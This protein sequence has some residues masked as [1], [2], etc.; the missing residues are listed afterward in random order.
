MFVSGIPSACEW[1]S[2]MGEGGGG[3]GGGQQL[4]GEE[5]GSKRGFHEG[6]IHQRE[7]HGIYQVEWSRIAK[8]R[9]PNYMYP[10]WNHQ[11]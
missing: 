10:S 7:L 4:E 8:K 2:L 5:G 3:G 9:P 1:S 11:K 6:S